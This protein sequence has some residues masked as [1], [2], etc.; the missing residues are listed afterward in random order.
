[1]MMLHHTQIGLSKPACMV[2][3]RSK[4]ISY[5][6]VVCMYVCIILL[7]EYIQQQYMHASCRLRPL[8]V[9]NQTHY[10]HPCTIT[11]VNTYQSLWIHL[12]IV[13]SVFVLTFSGLK[14]Q[15]SSPPHITCLFSNTCGVPTIHFAE[16]GDCACVAL[17]SHY[18]IERN[19]VTQLILC[20]MVLRL[21]L[22]NVGKLL[23][24]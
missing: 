4:I 13:T 21:H 18:S 23:M 3:S 15:T 10:Y 8:S 17:F 11:K 9:S 2:V 5:S 1:M 12:D 6:L 19:D 24:K 14:F 20:I 16:D 7:H 22:S